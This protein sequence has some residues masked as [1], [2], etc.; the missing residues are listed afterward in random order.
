MKK[1]GKPIIVGTSGEIEKTGLYKLISYKT[2][3]ILPPR[4]DREIIEKTFESIF[5]NRFAEEYLS[6]KIIL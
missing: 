1:I 4:Y 6:G 2:P 5:Y 3:Y